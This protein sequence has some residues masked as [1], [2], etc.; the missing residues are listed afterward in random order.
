M[1]YVIIKVP[2]FHIP[3]CSFVQ[4]IRA[5]HRCKN[6]T[7][8]LCN[9]EQNMKFKI[10]RAI[11]MVLAISR[12]GCAFPSGA[13]DELH[14]LVTVKNL[15]IKNT[16]IKMN[17]SVSGTHKGGEQNT[18]VPFKLTVDK[19]VVSGNEIVT[20][21][22]VQKENYA[23]ST[24]KG[25]LVEGLNQ[26]SGEILGDF[27]VTGDDSYVKPMT[28]YGSLGSAITH[29]NKN[30]KSSLTLKWKAPCLPKTTT[31]KFYATILAEIKMFWVKKATNSVQVESSSMDTCKSTGSSEYLL[32]NTLTLF[33]LSWIT[34]LMV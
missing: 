19:S 32:A 20:I 16:C 7:F 8:T 30:E 28:C 1:L 26:E 11:A 13:P 34:V 24:F 29:K 33:V 5:C 21:M 6:I 3:Q 9:M 12:T 10:Y 31:V 25:V 14:E 15:T 17:P 18:T 27:V 23:N 4:L 2:I 22:I